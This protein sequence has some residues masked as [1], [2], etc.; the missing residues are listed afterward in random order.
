MHS[1]LYEDFL[2][3]N[4]TQSKKTLEIQSS[5]TVWRDRSY[6]MSCLREGGGVSFEGGCNLKTSPFWEVSFSLVR[7]AKGGGVKC[8][9]I[10]KAV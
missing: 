6:I 9:G 1:I 3:K 7:N 4:V 8:C 10:A 5:L 2:E